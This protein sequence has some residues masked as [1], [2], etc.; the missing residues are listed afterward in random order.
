MKK[1]DIKGMLADKF[2]DFE[3]ELDAP[4]WPEIERKL[5]RDKKALLFPWRL[6]LAASLG[7]GVSLALYFYPRAGENNVVKGKRPEI[8]WVD[9]TTKKVV[10]PLPGVVQELVAT[11]KE[12]DTNSQ[13]AERAQQGSIGT[14]G[15]PTIVED[16]TGIKEIISVNPMQNNLATVI[17]A[18]TVT[19]E[20]VTVLE[21][22]AGN[23]DEI[24]IGGKNR[25]IELDK[26]T[27]HEVAMFV[28]DKLEQKT[29]NPPLIAEKEVKEDKEV[30]TIRIHI[31]NF[32][33]VNK[34]Y[35]QTEVL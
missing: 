15:L 23:K 30:N 11:T 35:K 33:L 21:M 12:R 8:V 25:L 18:S 16:S 31:G 28:S 9:S 17:P 3:P 22:R 10:S 26:L 27:L 34:R 14:V 1:D 13:S 20:I 32:E 7:A 4:V 2:Q 19:P 6:V 24:M 5:E 29:E